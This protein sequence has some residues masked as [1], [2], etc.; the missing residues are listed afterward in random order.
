[1]VLSIVAFLFLSFISVVLL[2]TMVYNIIMFSDLEMDY[3]N[4]IDVCKKIN[5]VLVSIY[6]LTVP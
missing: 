6:F 1:M 4:P 2:F 5:I 3:I